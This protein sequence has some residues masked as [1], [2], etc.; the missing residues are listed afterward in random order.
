MPQLEHLR[1]RLTRDIGGSHLWKN[2]LAVVG[3][4]FESNGRRFYFEIHNIDPVTRN[5]RRKFELTVVG[6]T[7]A[8]LYVAG[9]GRR[10]VAQSDIDLIGAQSLRRPAKWQDHLG[11]LAK[12]NR[13]A[14]ERDRKRDPAGVGTV[15]PWCH[16]TF[17]AEGNDGAHGRI[18]TEPGDPPQHVAIEEILV[19]IDL[20]DWARALL[21]RS[22]GGG[23]TDQ[24]MVEGLR[25]GL[26][27]RP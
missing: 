7:Q 26:K 15:S 19:G 11:L 12:V 22:K 20:T 2:A 8:R 23:G 3:G 27:G 4:I 10:S 9:S 16:V 6:V 25:R 24:D 21:V 5:V 13:R 1:A 18:F 14:A 17:L